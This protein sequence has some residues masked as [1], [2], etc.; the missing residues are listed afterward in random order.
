M[1]RYGDVKGSGAA[2]GTAFLQCGWSLDTSE[3]M[4]TVE[5]QG[6]NVP[7]MKRGRWLMGYLDP[8]VGTINST[9]RAGVEEV[10][11]EA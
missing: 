10:Q 2:A 3:S 11:I 8:G 1:D 4:M 5:A 6:A 9:G 7:A